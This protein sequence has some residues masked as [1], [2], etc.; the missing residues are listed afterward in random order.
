[1]TVLL[2][3]KLTVFYY[4]QGYCLL[5]ESMLDTVLYARDKWL[6]PNG[7]VFPDKAVMYVCALEDAQVKSDRIDFWDDVYGFDM[8]PIKQVALREPVVDL[9]DSRV[10]ALSV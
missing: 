7:I 2:C 1:M 4:Y 8:T 6:V 5:Y 3:S 10:S 9:V